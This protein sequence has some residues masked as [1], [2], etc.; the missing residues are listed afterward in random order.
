MS[1]TFTPSLFNPAAVAGARTDKQGHTT[2]RLHDTLTYVYSP[3]IV[4][5]VNVARATGRP[6]LVEGKPGT[7]KTTLAENIAAVLRWK[8]YPQVVTSRTRAHDLM[9]RYDALRR[10]ADAQA[11]K[12]RPT[13]AYIEPQALWWAFDA[14]GATQRGAARLPRTIK[15]ATDPQGE[16]DSDCAVV[17]IDEIDKAEPDVPN[18]LL[19]ALD[20]A[21]FTVDDLDPPRAVQGERAKVLMLITTNG[22]RE[23][24]A[25]FVR[26]CVVL[27]LQ[28][29]SAEAL[30]MIAN[31]RFGSGG[32]LLHREV[33]AR[34]MVLRKQADE[35]RHREPSTAEYLD[36]VGACRDLGITTTSAEW[37]LL[38]QAALWKRDTAVP[39]LVAAS[40][41]APGV[42]PGA[43]PGALAGASTGAAA[44]TSPNLPPSPAA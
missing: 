25:A 26:R 38:E 40:S 13:E 41:P 14:A 37:Q 31:Q 21:R 28:Q 43:A 23:L 6:L 5:A 35:N 29:P 15:P 19:Q 3:P 12:L 32:Q 39:A 36:A 44:G 17:L 9:W 8:F 33:A 34:L 11:K 18:D 27:T 22:E 16:V 4:L 24:P 42:P 2:V 1:R 20:E 10:L 7:G 30:V